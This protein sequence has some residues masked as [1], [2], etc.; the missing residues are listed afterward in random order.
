LDWRLDGEKYS[1]A[2]SRIIK[3]NYPESLID[4]APPGDGDRAK[5]KQWFMHE[6]L[7]EGAARNKAATYLLIGNPTPGESVQRSA[8]GTKVK[9]EAPAKPQN[10]KRSSAKAAPISSETRAANV[11]GGEAE[12]NPASGSSRDGIPLNINLQI[13]I[14]ADA[15]PEQIEAVFSAMKRYLYDK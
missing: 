1:S 12:A 14:G 4:V 9:E 2:V 3:N 7:G 6:G 11:V 13:H 10:R 15:S 5:A 8:N